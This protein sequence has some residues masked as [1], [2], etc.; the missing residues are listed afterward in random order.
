MADTS[1]KIESCM[2]FGLF[3]IARVPWRM[4]H[5]WLTFQSERH[6][7]SLFLHTRSQLISGWRLGHGPHTVLIPACVTW[8]LFLPVGDFQFPLDLCLL[9]MALAMAC[10]PRS[11]RDL[12]SVACIDSMA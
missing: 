7:A 6:G 12:K 11:Y 5:V 10:V 4:A 8:C 3:A 9:K 2:T 1:L